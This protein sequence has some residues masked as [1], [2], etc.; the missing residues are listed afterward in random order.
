MQEPV[1]PD[2]KV[3]KSSLDRRLE[4]DDLAL[5]DVA[6]VT[7]EARPLDVQLLKNPVLHDRDPALLG[8]EYVYQH[9][10]LHAVVFLTLSRWLLFGLGASTLLGDDGIGSST[11][12]CEA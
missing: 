6:S 9:F 5:I 1:A 10:F 12:A 4:I 2:G 7:L 11:K 8:L 3:N